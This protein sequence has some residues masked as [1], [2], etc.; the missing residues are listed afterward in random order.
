MS[1]FEMHVLL[2]FCNNFIFCSTG[3]S[4][5]QVNFYAGKLSVFDACLLSQGT[6]FHF[7]SPFGEVMSTATCAEA[8]KLGPL[9]YPGM[10][11]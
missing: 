7:T 9:R 5:L 11:A 4:L 8:S 10:L 6:A 3:S 1:V 2:N